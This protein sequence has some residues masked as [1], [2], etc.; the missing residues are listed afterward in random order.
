MRALVVKFGGSILEGG[1]SFLGAADIV[2]D[3][4]EQE[5]APIV[6]ISAMKGITDKL[7]SVMEGTEG[8]LRQVFDLHR[9][10]ASDLNLPKEAMREI[11]DLLNELSRTVWAVRMLKEATPRVRDYVLSFGE[12]LSALLMS[13]VLTSRGVRST[14]MTGGDAGV[15]TTRDFGEA[16]PITRRTYPRIRRKIRPLLLEGVVPVITGFL[17]MTPEG[18][19]TTL[20][21]GG[22]DLSATL[23]ASALNASE[24]RF[25]T[26]VEGVLTANPEIVPNARTIN[27]LS[28]E[29]AMELSYLGA[30]RFHPSTFEPLIRSGVPAR[31]I[32]FHNPKGSST[33]VK[34]T[35][36]CQ[37]KVKAVLAVSDLALV[38]VRG[39][40][41]VGRIGTAAEIASLARD[42]GVNICAISQPVS[43]TV[44]DV[45]VRK[46]C[47]KRFSNLVERRLKSKKVVSSVKVKEDLS[48]VVVVGCGLRSP[49]NFQKVL[50]LLKHMNVYLISRGGERVSLTLLVDS[51]RA[52]ELVRRIHDEV[53]VDG[54][55]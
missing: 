44:I 37:D 42:S 55:A 12:R 24:V 15:I 47:S 32:S 20:G 53:V 33:L 9:E 45:V 34:G 4:M 40:T 27:R 11:S 18:D 41:M 30:K 13:H 22:S 38:E 14:W 36:D 8:H 35:C 3:L 28:L 19:I 7:R 50:R 23:I 25:Y 52:V 2:L 10:V 29:E 46:D 17:G 1:Y 39:T 21:R 5:C 16:R 49:H 48:A 51:D 43:E 54:P 26:D 6:V 31:I